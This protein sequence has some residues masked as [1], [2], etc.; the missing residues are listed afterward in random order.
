MGGYIYLICDPSID[1][2]KIGV[3]RNIKSN[4]IKKLQ[5]G[6]PTELHIVK[7]YKCDYPFR[8]EKMLHNKFSNK[9]DL[10]E[11]FALDTHDIINFSNT[12]NEINETIKCLLDN[13]FFAK[14]IK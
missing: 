6:N 9:R 5:T 14:D 12:C 8:L 11:W 3:T 4:R 2:F 13:P 1:A 10:N 7:T